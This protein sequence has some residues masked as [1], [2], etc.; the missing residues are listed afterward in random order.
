VKS[1]A[2][3]EPDARRSGRIRLVGIAIL[4][5][6]AVLIG[7]EARLTASLRTAWFDAFQILAPRIPQSM[8][9]TV[10]EIDQKSLERFGQ[11]PWPR[12]VMAELV[13]AIGR[14]RPAAIAL[15]ILMPEADALSPERALAH[16]RKK[17]AALARVLAGL[18]S[19]DA[20]LARALT[21]A[22]AILVVAGMPEP[23]G[24]PLRAPP[25]IVRDALGN[26]AAAAPVAPNL[27]RYPGA[28]TSI[29]ELDRAA[30]GHGLIS[31]DPD[32]GIIRRI[33]LAASID[34]TLVPA[35]AIEMLRI[36]VGAPAVRLQ[37]S[38]R[39]VQ[40]IAVGDFSVSTEADGAVR[41]YY[42]RRRVDRFVAAVDVLEGRVDPARLERKLVLIGVTGL[43]LL[44]YQNTPVGERMPGSE[45][46]AQLVE[47]LF[48]GTLLHRPAW[49]PMVEMALFLGLGAWL[50]AV[51][52]RWKPR[53]AALVMLG[54]IAL[55]AALA[56]V[57][58]RAERLL[59]DAATPAVGLVLLFGVLLFLTLAEATRQKKALERQV[60]VQREQSARIAGE[61]EAARRIQTSTLPRADLLQG[62]GRIDIAAIMIPARETG[63]DL[64]DFLRLDDRRLFFLV[65][66]VAGKGLS[67]S[68]FMAVSKALYKSATLRAADADVGALM[69]VANAEVSRDNQEMLFVTAFAGILDLETGRLDY[70]NAGHDNPYLI[71]PADAA[72]RRIDDGDGPP[73]CAISDFEYRGGRYAMR[74]GELL[75]AITDGVSE[76]RNP[77]GALYG[78]ARVEAILRRPDSGAA[79]ARGVVAALKADVEAFAAGAEAADD[80]TI[81]ALRWRGPGAAG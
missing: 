14:D 3:V 46:H 24:M 81:L 5:A 80:L 33:P 66:D 52:P 79:S 7:R 23:T 27:V 75:C 10:V 40:R 71:D 58:F 64:Y 26:A 37:V 78:G 19:N 63:G 74:P 32:V 11:W 35:L 31:V 49:A 12:T 65:G 54:G 50:V 61:L 6:L 1:A 20:V 47:N 57:A 21:D 39:T 41:P 30:S 68:I 13:D 15:D 45:I 9:V 67:A 18:P 73:L 72:V 16:A 34:G 53:N 43:G 17:D 62:D 44:E 29:E 2:A 36:A 60:Q 42:S 25:F 76:A 48:D 56:F 8:P 4:V 70:C 22:G 28:L 51:T 55:P 59:F 69:A 38:G 77:A